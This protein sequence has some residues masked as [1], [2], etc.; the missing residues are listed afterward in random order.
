MAGEL[1]ELRASD[2]CFSLA[3]SRALLADFGAEVTAAD[4][5]LLH[6]RSDGWAAALQMAALSLS[7]FPR[8]G[9]GG[10]GAGHPQS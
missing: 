8:S 3:E 7:W 9:A 5:A 10:A 2:L 6:Q 4:L 1:C